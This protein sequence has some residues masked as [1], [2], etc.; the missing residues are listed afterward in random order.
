MEP[1]DIVLLTYNRLD[2]L[3]QT[4]DALYERT[5]EPFRLTVVDNASASDVRNWLSQNRSRFHRVILQPDN[6]H[7]AGFQRGIDATTSDPFIVAEPDL[8]VPELQP[9]W[10]AR[11]RGLLDRHS[12]FGLIGLGLDPVNRPAVLGPEQIDAE[13]LVGGELVESNVGIWFQ[14]IRRD[15]LHVPYEKDA[16]VC[17]AIREAGFRVGWTPAIRA[18]HLGWD[19]YARHPVHL[20]SKNELPSPYPYYR[21]VDLIARPPFLAEVAAAAPVVAELRAAEVP[22]GSVVEASW[23]APVVGA[24][25]DDV[26]TIRPAAIP[27]PFSEGAAGAVVLVEPPPDAAEEALLNA[28]HVATRLIVVLCPLATF[29]GRPASDLAPPGWTGTER[30]AIGQLPLEL[31]R[32]GDALPSMSTHARFTTLEDRDRWLTL[33]AHGAFEPSG[34]TR[35]FV[36]ESHEERA[37]PARVIGAENAQR[38]RPEPRVPPAP[39]LAQR[40]RYEIG[41]RTPAPLRR[42]VRRIRRAAPR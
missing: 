28:A 5:P 26:V 17:M 25:L 20:A 29:G 8:I 4:V 16:A 34:Q 2:Y 13:A 6:E 14:M 38:W 40:A 31:A 33:F 22:L 24:A 9:S 42:F 21:E 10:L 15:A 35:L 19:D 27:L 23:G 32:C 36:F 1:V 7:I 41:S 3:A 30:P 37:M 18:F 11:L 39:T 12:D